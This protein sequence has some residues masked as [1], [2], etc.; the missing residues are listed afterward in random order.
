MDRAGKIRIEKEVGGMAIEIE[1][2]FDTYHG[3]GRWEN[4]LKSFKREKQNEVDEAQTVTVVIFYW[5]GLSGICK[6]S[7]QNRKCTAWDF[8][9]SATN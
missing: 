5:S 8:V 4:V 2:D 3:G 1:M 6:S 9:K 7:K